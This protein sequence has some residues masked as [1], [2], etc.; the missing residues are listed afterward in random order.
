[1]GSNERTAAVA[2]TGIVSIALDALGKTFRLFWNE[3]TC[4]CNVLIGL[5]N[6]IKAE[7]ALP[8]DINNNIPSIC[9]DKIVLGE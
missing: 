2:A 9:N 4:F 7:L 5:L 1:M 3:K 6:P 8:S